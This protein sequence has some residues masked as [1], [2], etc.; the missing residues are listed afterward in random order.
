MES[1]TSNYL[2]TLHDLLHKL[3]SEVNST[4][5]YP[6]I[7]HFNNSKHLISAIHEVDSFI[8]SKDRSLNESGEFSEDVSKPM[9]NALSSHLHLFVNGYAISTLAVMGLMINLIG[10]LLLSTGPR[11][12]KVLNSLVAFRLSFDA[13]FLLC[14]LLKSLKI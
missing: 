5:S 2:S 9:T 7:D 8:I 11:R 14:E 6:N 4:G 10:I 12:D 13:S 3:S 1:S